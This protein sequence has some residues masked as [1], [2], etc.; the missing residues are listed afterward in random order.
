MKNDM[1]IE[2]IR[3]DIAMQENNLQLETRKVETVTKV[4]GISYARSH[5]F[6]LPQMPTSLVLGILVGTSIFWVFMLYFLFT[7]FRSAIY[8]LTKTQFTALSI[9]IHKKTGWSQ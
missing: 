4:M 2:K 7:M 5:H 8:C 1:Y 9:Q 6:W 3:R